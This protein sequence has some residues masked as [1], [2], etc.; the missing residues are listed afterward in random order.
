MDWISNWFHV[1]LRS[2]DFLCQIWIQNETWSQIFIENIDVDVI[3]FLD[4]IPA[5]NPIECRIS[6]WNFSMLNWFHY[7]KKMNLIKFM[8]NFDQKIN[9]TFNS[10]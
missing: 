9:L 10:V 7:K 1:E 5:F 8:S 4:L 2:N 6:I 3:F